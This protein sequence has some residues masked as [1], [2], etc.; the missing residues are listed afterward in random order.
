MP[1]TSFMM[2]T[3]SSL[4]SAILTVVSLARLSVSKCW[5]LQ[6]QCCNSSYLLLLLLL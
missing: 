3:S 5:C 2:V 6:E 4:L 1:L